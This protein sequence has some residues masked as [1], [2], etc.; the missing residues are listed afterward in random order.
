VIPSDDPHIPERLATEVAE[1][2]PLSGDGRGLLAPNLTPGQF[3]ALL[4]SQELYADAIRFT[5]FDFSNREAVWWGALCLWEACRSGVDQPKTPPSD[6]VFQSL[7]AWLQKPSED[8]RRTVE[9]AG[10]EAGITTPRGQLAMAAF[11]T[12]GSMSL[13]GQPEVKPE[14]WFTSKNVASVVLA[15]SKTGRP[16]K[17]EE[18]QRRFLVLAAELAKGQLPWHIHDDADLATSTV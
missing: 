4:I 11:F 9:T 15:A 12:E 13:P 16:S 1:H 5:A 7:I 8:N 17:V 2:C 18:S 10:R 6:P 14:P 3:I